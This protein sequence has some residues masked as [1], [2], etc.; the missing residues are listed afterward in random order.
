MIFH[1]HT[2]LV[3]VYPSKDHQG[4]CES[5]PQLNSIPD[6][7]EIFIFNLLLITV[8]ILYCDYSYKR[9]RNKTQYPSGKIVE[10]TLEDLKETGGERE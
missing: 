3:K 6:L 4:Q 8:R 10:D 7:T 2:V 9:Y 5:I 1:Q